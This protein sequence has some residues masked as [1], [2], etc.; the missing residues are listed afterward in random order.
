MSE[1]ENKAALGK[2]LTGFSSEDVS[3]L[4]PFLEAKDI[5]GGTVVI[6][7]GAGFRCLLFARWGVLGAREGQYQ[8]FIGYLEHGH[9]FG[10]QHSW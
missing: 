9:I 2:L 7:H 4:M 6:T 8:W 10:P 5:L 3:R 1:S